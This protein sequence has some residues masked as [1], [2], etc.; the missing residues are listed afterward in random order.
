MNSSTKKGNG[1]SKARNRTEPSAPEILFN[2]LRIDEG[3]LY[4]WILEI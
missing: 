1:S 4:Q 3:V 2:S